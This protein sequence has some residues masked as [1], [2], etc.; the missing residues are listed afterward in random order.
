MQGI[1]LSCFLE[2]NVGPGQRTLSG[3]LHRQPAQSAAPQGP[4]GS[5][6][7]FTD[8]QGWKQTFLDAQT[9][10]AIAQHMQEFR[11]WKAEN[12]G[13]AW[14]G[15]VW[16]DL[17]GNGEHPISA[18]IA[19]L[20]AVL[21]APG[22]LDGLQHMLEPSCSLVQEVPS[23]HAVCCAGS[24]TE[25]QDLLQLLQ[26]GAP[27]FEPGSFDGLHHMPGPDRSFL[28]E[29]RLNSKPHIRRILQHQ[30][31]E[32]EAQQPQ[33]LQA[34]TE[35]SQK[36]FPQ[37]QAQAARA[38]PST[39]CIGE[40]EMAPSWRPARPASPRQQADRPEERAQ[41]VA[42][43]HQAPK[44]Q[45]VPAGSW[46]P[47]TA[48]QMLKRQR[49][50]AHPEQ[51][52]Q[53]PVL[54]HL[55]SKTAQCEG[56]P[57]HVQPQP[58][59]QQQ[60]ILE[61]G[62]CRESEHAHH[63]DSPDQSFRDEAADDDANWDHLGCPAEQL[64]GREGNCSKSPQGLCDEDCEAGQELAWAESP[65]GFGEGPGEVHSAKTGSEQ[66]GTARAP[67]TWS[68]Q[69]CTFAGTRAQI[70]R[71]A[72][73]NAVRGTGW[74]YYQS[75]VAEQSAPPPTSDSGPEG[76]R[77]GHGRASASRGMAPS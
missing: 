72:M 37:Q 33:P 61:D 45:D 71:C 35:S 26:P 21:T 24:Q 60:Q 39:L 16:H 58:Q 51:Q 12:P 10:Q 59:Q 1:R 76:E 8:R 40:H 14:P 5:P 62:A 13:A 2:T 32:A 4:P 31:S 75:A 19:L 52:Q 65:P 7:E 44:L 18:C 11:Q 42:E 3:Y 66:T 54:F 9:R 36:Q 64:E 70:L 20:A 47:V 30:Q 77:R 6:P 48:S 23:P 29:Y 25:T 57:L 74:G 53:Q 34:A 73:C 28:Q 27:A 50:T 17:P 41:A 43:P 46:R 69:V 55:S 15:N 22:I 49:V 67:R 56:P 63:S 38:G 68:C